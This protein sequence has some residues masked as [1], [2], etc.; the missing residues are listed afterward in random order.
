VLD[1]P[2]LPRIPALELFPVV[3]GGRLPAK[4]TQGE[5]FPIRAT[6]FREGHGAFAAEAV[7]ID[8]S[9]CVRSRTPM[10]D[11]APGLDRL[12]AW[13]C[14]DSTGPWGFRVD[15]WSDSYAS[16]RHDATVKIGAG[17]DVELMLEEGA[18]LLER[19]ASGRA[20][21]NPAQS[22]P[23]EPGRSVLLEAAAAARDGD[24]S[25]Q[26]RL[27]AA[28]S[29]R[30][31]DVLAAHP[32]R[33]LYG[34]TETYPLHVARPRA[35]HGSWYEIFPRSEG[36][37]QRPDG[38]W[39]SGTLR[40]A[41]EDLPRIAGMG[42]DVVYLTPVHP[43]GTTFRKGRNNA[44]HAGPGDPGSPYAVGSAEGGHDALH[45]DLGDFDDF[46]AFVGRARG[47]GME[48]ALDLALQCSPDHPWVAEHPE[49][50]T[51]RADGS[52]AY[53]E[54]PPKK[55][56]DI[57]P[58]NFDNDPEGIYRA[59]WDLIELWASHGVSI[60]RVDNPH[61][62]PVRFWQ[63]LMRE[64]HRAHP[65]LLFLAEAFTRPAMMRTLG[66]VGFDQSY[67][68]FAWRTAKEEIQDYLREVSTETAHLLRPA[69]WPVTPDILTEQMTAGGT[70][71]FAIRAI[72]AAT[73]SPTW[74]IYSG[75]EFAEG[76]QRPGFEEPNDNEKYEYRPRDWSQ[77]EPTGIPRL[78]GLLNAARAAHPA[79][80]QLHR[81]SIHPTSHPSL[82][83]FSRHVDGRF[84]PSGRDDT[85]IVVLSLDP[86]QEVEGTV[87]LS[88]L[89]DA[90][91]PLVDE[92]DGRSYSWGASN[93]VRLGPWTRLAHVM[94]V[95]AAP[96][97]TWEQKR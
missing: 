27:A 4:A 94:A 58:L 55:Y 3:E 30:V 66:A 59:V 44:L 93:Y 86:R 34:H 51:T 81:L 49:W 37:V 87:D 80:Q 8:P 14:A 2:D 79:L 12:E 77:A 82:L 63:R 5:P 85:V 90:R 38:S 47:L 96:A 78:L 52:I 65:D 31:R 41:A 24:R 76:V 46:D 23:G 83:C 84:T 32:L 28:T 60:F 54:N 22:A 75:Y 10:V 88:A 69:F 74:G 70:A 42:F 26:Q 91:L 18:L 36:A 71:V 35:V 11:I 13:V 48:V 62:K 9:G 50:F 29:P 45:P 68:Y 16:W 95:E 61:T 43:V 97:T 57:Y 53:A 17:I 72:L 64:M 92:L 33:D 39:V 40:T 1:A 21:R 89:G 15:T 7:L 67:T 6:V 25:A 73:G 20:E 56:Q 19:A